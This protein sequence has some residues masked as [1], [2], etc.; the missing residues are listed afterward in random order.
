MTWMLTATGAVFDLFYLGREAISLL[1]IAHHLAQTNRYN[2]A[3]QR[4]VSVAEHSLMVCDILERAHGER[5]PEVLLAALMHDAHEAYTGDMTQPLKRAFRE[6]ANDAWDRF[7]RRV[8]HQVLRHFDLLE[9]FKTNEQAIH[10]ADMTALATERAQVMA[11]GGPPWEVEATHQAVTW[12]DMQAQARFAWD[13][14]R[15]AFIDRYGELNFARQLRAG[16]IGA[17]A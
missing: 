17:T 5:R 2:G 10:W 13:D 16:G 14:W 3:A 8:Q 7:E 12:I 15:Q 9:P 11:Q 6:Y 1:D 4:P